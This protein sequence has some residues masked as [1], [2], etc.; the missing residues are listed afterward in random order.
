MKPDPGGGSD[1]R[2]AA[3]YRAARYRVDAPGRELVLRVGRRSRRLDALL[4]ARGAERFAWLTAVNP[5]SRR[6]GE[7]ENARRLARLDAEIARRG[8]RALPGTSLDPRGLWPDEPSRLVLDVDAE[9]ARELARQF[10]QNAL[11]VGSC[12]EPVRLLRVAAPPRAG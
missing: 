6:L 9:T 11:L 7:R 4:A 2:L 12:G 10:G 8:W 5:G 1:A 3:A